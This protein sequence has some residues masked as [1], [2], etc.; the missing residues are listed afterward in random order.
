[1]YGSMWVGMM[2][3]YGGK[4][5]LATNPLKGLSDKIEIDLKYYGWKDINKVGQPILSL[6]S[7]KYQNIDTFLSIKLLTNPF[8]HLRIFNWYGDKTFL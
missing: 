8:F 4:K 7:T 1:M 2:K 6:D 3:I 5:S